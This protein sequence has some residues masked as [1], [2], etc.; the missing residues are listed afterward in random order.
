M[1]YK[2]IL[3]KTNQNSFYIY[4]L[5]GPAQKQTYQA[6]KATYHW[7]SGMQE[8]HQHT[9]GPDVSHLNAEALA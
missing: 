6:S 4:F 8:Y 5:N 3:C 2:K 1:K 9:Q 7:K